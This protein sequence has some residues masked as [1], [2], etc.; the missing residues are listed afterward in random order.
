MIRPA[1]RLLPAPVRRSISRALPAYTDRRMRGVPQRRWA[2]DSDPP[3][4]RAGEVVAPPDFVGIG[5][6]KSGTSW[7]FSAMLRHHR[8]HDNPDVHKEVHFFH[9]MWQK[10]YRS[11]DLATYERWFARPPGLLSGEWTPGYAASQWML[12]LV[13]QAAPDAKVL[14]LFRDPVAR[15]HSHL[16]HA[17]RSGRTLDAVTIDR[18]YRASCYGE[19]ITRVR[20]V[21]EPDQVLYLQYEKCAR[22]PDAHLRT[23]FEFLGLAHE[24]IDVAAVRPGV[25]KSLVAPHVVAAMTPGLRAEADAAAALVPEIDL[26]LWTETLESDE[27]P[28]TAAGV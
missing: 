1:S 25:S 8:I 17:V 11:S 18:A 4:P 12:P 15:M 23:T 20:D 27:H 19:L 21:F 2:R 28:S 10:S 9:D 3:P 26:S 22:H 5:T 16:N 14:V 24:P 6:M 7:W 13:K